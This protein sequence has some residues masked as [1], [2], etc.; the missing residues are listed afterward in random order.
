MAKRKRLTPAPGPE[1]AA[2]ASADTGFARETFAPRGG[3]GGALPPIAAM[4]GDI[5]RRAATEEIAAELETARRDGRL[6]EELP[7][8]AI[9][10]DHLI[11]DRATLDADEMT[12]LIDSLR[13]RG[14]Q[15][16]IEVTPIGDKRYGLI[17]GWRRLEALRRLAAEGQGAGIVL[18]FVRRPETAADAYLAM[19]EENEIRADLGFWERGRIVAR[20]VD[21]GVYPDTKQALNGLFGSVSRSKRSKIGSFVLLVQALDGILRFPETL[22]ERQGLALAG[23]LKG[24]T[25]ASGFVDRIQAAVTEGAPADPDAE[26]ALVEACLQDTSTGTPQGGKPAPNVRDAGDT[27]RRGV[28]LS[29]SRAGGALTLTLTGPSVDAAFRKRLSAWLKREAEG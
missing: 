24:A 16:P 4:T 18:A 29:E 15:T 10:A 28:K 19:V 21:A 12:A 8:E 6:A 7:L 5:A 27:T 22:S 20:A 25:D 23:R 3:E 13:S 1:T 14:Q 11:R 2:E 26:W 17:S 9:V